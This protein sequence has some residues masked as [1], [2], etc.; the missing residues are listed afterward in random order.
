MGMTK[1]Q[2]YKCI[3]IASLKG[4]GREDLTWVTLEMSE[5]YG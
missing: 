4:M 3:K 1:E 2:Y 5:Y